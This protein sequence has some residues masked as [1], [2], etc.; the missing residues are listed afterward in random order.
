MAD[1]CLSN[2]DEE[3]R[4]AALLNCLANDIVSGRVRLI[5][6]DHHRETN[7]CFT[8]GVA[9]ACLTGRETL[10]IHFCRPSKE[11]NS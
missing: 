5:E 2:R 3:L 6:A 9:T 7:T 11:D 1:Y 10:S 8:L 4:F